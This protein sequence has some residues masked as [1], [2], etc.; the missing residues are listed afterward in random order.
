MYLSSLHD[1]GQPHLPSEKRE[2]RKVAHLTGLYLGGTWVLGK[3][4]TGK[5]FDRL[6]TVLG[7][8]CCFLVIV[9]DT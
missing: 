5:A 3:P 6:G 7:G 8:R 2:L 4:L 1:A 9:F